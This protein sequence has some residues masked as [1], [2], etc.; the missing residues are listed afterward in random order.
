MTLQHH[1]VVFIE[2]GKAF[3]DYDSTG[4]RFYAGEVWNTEI[5]NWEDK[6]EHPEEY[7]KAHDLIENLLMKG[8]K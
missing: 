8:K 1:F 3:I 6:N 4:D 7:E 2:D 5:E